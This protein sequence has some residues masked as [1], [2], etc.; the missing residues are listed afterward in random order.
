VLTVD[1]LTVVL[2]GCAVL[3]DVRLRLGPGE[4]TVLVGPN[5]AGKS[6]LL[7]AIAGLVPA[8]GSVCLDGAPPGRAA[9]YMP[10]DNRA[11]GLTVLETVLLGRLDRLGLRVPA[12]LRAE[13]LDLL[14]RFRLD[15]LA[16]RPLEELS[17]G[18]R[19]LVFLAQTLFR[20]PRV[21]LLD[22]PTAALDLR[23]Q[24]TVLERVVEETRQRGTITLLALHDL[25]LA[26]RMA[27][28]IVCLA[29][30]RVVA[31]GPPRAVLQRGLLRSVWGIEAEIAQLASG[32]LAIVPLA[33]ADGTAT[34]E[35]AGHGGGEAR[36]FPRP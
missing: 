30:G 11:G 22:E 6:T 21:L 23:H 12:E 4:V 18:Q 33:V 26:A 24:L 16:W 5:G 2:G 15:R 17:G 28:R 14:A 10:Q 34:L 29:G 13:A 1:G 9:A 20:R 19:Q 32:L 3:E 31:E 8:R 7:R 36:P 25:T 27:G 35:A